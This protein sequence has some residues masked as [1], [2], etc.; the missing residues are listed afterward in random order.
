MPR[1]YS[2]AKVA[3]TCEACAATFYRSPN[4]VRNSACR[5]CSWQC[6]GV[7]RKPALKIELICEHCGLKFYRHPDH[8]RRCR[9]RFCSSKCTNHKHGETADGKRTPEYGVWVGMRQRCS[10][11]RKAQYKDYGGRGIA[12]CPEWDDF[13]RFLADMGERPS[14]KHTLELRDHDGP[15]AAWNCLWS[16]MIGQANNTR[17]NHWLEYRGRKQTVAQWCRELGMSVSA[18][19]GR[20][21][22]GWLVEDALST[23]VGHR[24]GTDKKRH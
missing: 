17:V 7:N 12:V 6:A 4:V 20:L 11:P 13:G 15:Y 14:P 16:T 5:F 18:L 8:L 1:Q 23:P 24:P 10:N 3:L 21:R 22:R 2:F 19:R 9:A